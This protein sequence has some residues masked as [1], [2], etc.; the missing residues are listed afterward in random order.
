VLAHIYTKMQGPQISTKDLSRESLVLMW[1]C[2]ESQPAAAF[3]WHRARLA[4]LEVEGDMEDIPHP[5]LINVVHYVLVVKQATLQ[6]RRQ[7]FH[8]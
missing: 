3:Y 5:Y 1:G 6:S 7:Y 8:S 2:A 4:S